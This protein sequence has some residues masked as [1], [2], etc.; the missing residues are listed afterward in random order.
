[1]H[2]QRLLHVRVLAAKLTSNT[3]TKA[4]TNTTHIHR[5]IQRQIYVKAEWNMIYIYISTYK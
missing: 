1:M 5:H 3:K 4:G 2:S